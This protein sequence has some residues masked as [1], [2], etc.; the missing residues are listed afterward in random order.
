MTTDRR[1]YYDQFQTGAIF[2]AIT[3]LACAWC[4]CAGYLRSKSTPTG[5]GFC[6]NCPWR[7]PRTTHRSRRTA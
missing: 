1:I 2:M 6:Q 7:D 5:S 3:L 4:V